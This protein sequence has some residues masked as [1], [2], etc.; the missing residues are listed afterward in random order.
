[1]GDH[2]VTRLP[3]C[4]YMSTLGRSAP[5]KG[6]R[7]GLRTGG[8]DQTVVRDKLTRPEHDA[9][10]MP[11]QRRHNRARPPGDLVLV[12]GMGVM[13]DER[14]GVQVAGQV[15][16]EGHP[17]IGMRCF[18]A[19]ESDRRASVGQAFRA[20]GSCGACANYDNLVNFTAH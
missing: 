3:V 11:I 16:A 19:D 12:Q 14:V 17:V 4:G 8:E 20:P 7:T 1:M 9:F 15:L 10:G 5:G 6:R 13:G 2:L 18:T